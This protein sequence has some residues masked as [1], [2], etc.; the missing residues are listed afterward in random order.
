MNLDP[1]FVV[2]EQKIMRRNI[3]VGKGRS[4]IIFGAVI[5]I[6]R[7]N[8]RQTEPFL[9]RDSCY[10]PPNKRLFIVLD[11]KYTN[12]MSKEDEKLWELFFYDHLNK[13]DSELILVVKILFH[14][15]FIPCNLRIKKFLPRNF[16]EKGKTI[17]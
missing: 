10:P 15:N 12:S 5:E 14:F 9:A 1:L 6:S 16:G 7:R 2:S 8:Q 3:K 4:R 11:Q 13:K 17:F